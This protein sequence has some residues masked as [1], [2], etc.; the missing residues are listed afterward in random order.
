VRR[1]PPWQVIDPGQAQVLA[2][3]SKLYLRLWIAG[4]QNDFLGQPSLQYTQ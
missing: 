4:S 2:S 1:G 3:G